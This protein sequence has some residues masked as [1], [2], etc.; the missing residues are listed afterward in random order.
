MIFSF[1]FLVLTKSVHV[2]I[3]TYVF[4]LSMPVIFHLADLKNM[5]LFTVIVK[6]SVYISAMAESKNDQT[7]H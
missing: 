4:H 5:E 1:Q 7:S 6:V 2:I 3:C